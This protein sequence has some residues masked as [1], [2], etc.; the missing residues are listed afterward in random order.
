MTLKTHITF[1]LAI[2][3]TPIAIYSFIFHKELIPQEYTLYYIGFLLLGTAFPDIDEPESAI[4]RRTRI[5][6]DIIKSIFGHRGFTHSL[7]YI[8]LLSL[9]PLYFY[10]IKQN[11]IYYYS[12]LAFVLGNLAHILGDM[13]TYGGVPLFWPIKK[14]KKHIIPKPFQF[15]TN[16]LKEH[17]FS[18]IIF[19]PM[20]IISMLYLILS[21][22][23]SI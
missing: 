14:T 22:L 3:L 2:N 23:K 4:G 12:T 6:S 13:W 7:F 9:M 10:Y 18:F 8:L 1:S 15:K 17:F 19:L 5:I 21:Y 11:D 20:A 16:S